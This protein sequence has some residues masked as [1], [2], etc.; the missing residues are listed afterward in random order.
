VVVI[1]LGSAALWVILSG[2]WELYS[3][4]R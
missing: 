3:L 1:A 2:L 4:G